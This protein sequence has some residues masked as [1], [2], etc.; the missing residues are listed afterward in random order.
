[1]KRY[2]AAF[3]LAVCFA[4]S[5][6]QQADPCAG[7]AGVALGQCQGNQQK[8]LRQQLDQQQRQIQT[9]Q[10]RQNQLDQQQRQIQAQLENMRLQNEMLRNQ[11]DEEKSANQSAQPPATDNAKSAALKTL[12]V[13]SWKSDNPWYG[14]DYAKTQFAMRY[15]RQL[16]QERPELVGRPFLDAISAKVRDTFPAAN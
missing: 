14:T 10:E 16:Q 12:E 7:L 6:A 1:M 15:A 4:T 3:P 11:L 2:F 5:Y 13:R 9:Q 8:L